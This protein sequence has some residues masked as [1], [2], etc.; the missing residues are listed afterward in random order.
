NPLELSLFWQTDEQTDTSFRVFVQL[1]NEAGQ[2]VA[3]SDQEP[4]VWSRPTTSWIRGEYIT[5]PHTLHLP[6]D[7]PSGDYTLIAGMYNPIN[8]QRL[9]TR[10]GTDAVIIQELTLNNE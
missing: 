2:P 7:L 5:D 8:G 4:A 6:A 3:V 1:L 10:A 9:T